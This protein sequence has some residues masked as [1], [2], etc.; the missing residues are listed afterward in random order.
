MK[1]L[2]IALVALA[3]VAPAFAQ[4]GP[5]AAP[6]R[7]AIIEFLSLDADQVAA[8]D[9][10][11]ADRD[12]AAEPVRQSIADVEAEL[13]DLWAAGDPDATEVG[14][15]V[16]ERRSLG[17]QLADIHAIYVTGFEALLDEEQAGKLG[18]IRRADR[19]Q[20]LIPAFRIWGFLT[21]DPF[22]HL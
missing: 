5:H 21:P 3:M 15:L 12:A 11:V 7:D 1:Q 18:F 20:P 8:W 10:L 14:L 22:P 19:A 9:Q 16:I 4:D 17:E 6:A 2:G 13:R